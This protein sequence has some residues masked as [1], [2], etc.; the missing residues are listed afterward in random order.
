[1]PDP[2]PGLVVW[3]PAVL[4]P[5][6]VAARPRPRSVGGGPT[7]G[8]SERTIRVD[9]GSWHVSYRGVLVSTVAQRRV[10]TA[11]RVGLG[12]RPGLLALPVWSYDVVPLPAGVNLEGRL[13]VPHS[14]GSSFSDGALYSQPAVRVVTVGAIARGATSA[15]LRI[16]HGVGEL[17]GIRFSYNHALYETGFPT[18]VSGSDWTVPLFPAVRAT[19]PAGAE[20]E[21]GMPTCLV[22]LATDDAMDIDF[23]ITRV[24]R[25]TVEFVEATNVWAALE[26]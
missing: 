26:E 2:I 14:D 9:R 25:P 15:T 16:V 19:I 5:S 18:A 23:D 3:P 24:A 8:G 22:H 13:L 17:A 20:L 12:G 6:G 7:I 10:W 21:L 1:M 11:I 4:R